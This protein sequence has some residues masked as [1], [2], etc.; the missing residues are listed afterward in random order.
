MKKPQ[1]VSLIVPTIPL[2]VC[3]SGRRWCDAAKRFVGP[4]QH[5]PKPVSTD[6][7]EPGER[8]FHVQ[9]LDAAPIRAQL[10]AHRDLVILWEVVSEHTPAV[11][12]H[13]AQIGVTRP[14][15]LQLAAIDDVPRA[16]S[17]RLALRMMELGAAVVL[18]DPLDLAVYAKLVHRRFL[19]QLDD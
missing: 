13:I 17:R 4:F 10:P 6:G 18:H 7:T 14:D 2:W 8:M 16:R 12:L 11:A 15:V 9:S 5:D 1:G 3:E 19:A